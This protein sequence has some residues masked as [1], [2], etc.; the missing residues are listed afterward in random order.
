MA[1]ALYLDVHVPL[2]IA[3]QLRRRGVDVLTAI[4]DEA[5]ELADDDLLRRASALN[6][7]LFTQDIRF[8][9]MAEQWQRREEDFT[10]LIFGH[11]LGATIGAFVRDLEVVAKATEVGDWRGT[12]MHLPL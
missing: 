11:Q 3:E 9:A 1:I 10:G 4:E 12:V 5:A 7:I 2:A 6:R 8:K